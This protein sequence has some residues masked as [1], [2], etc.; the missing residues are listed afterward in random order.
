MQPKKIVFVSLFILLFF[1]AR[2]HF[3]RTP[4]F[5]E[6]GIFA[7]LVINQPENPNI[8]LGGR[9]DGEN[10]Y[11]PP[12]HPIE[13]YS[14]IKICGSVFRPY[15]A[16]VDWQNDAEITPR[17]RFVFSLFQFVILL[18]VSL[19][20]VFLR[21]WPGHILLAAILAAVVISPIALKTS[22]NLQ[23]DGSVG[24]L[25]NGLFGLALMLLLRK[26]SINIFTGGILF[27]ASIFLGIGKQEWTMV[28]LVAMGISTVYFFV[29]K[30]KTSQKIKPH[31]VMLLIILVGL[32]I[33]NITSYLCMPEA[34]LGGFRVMWD[35]SG[36]EKVFDGQTATEAARLVY[37]TIHRLPWICTSLAL[38]AISGL[39]VLSNRRWPK[40]V[41]FF[42]FIFGLGLFGAFFISLHSS[43]PRYFA[44]SLVVLTMAT[45]AV[46][47]QK[48]NSRFFVM[49]AMITLIMFVS[50]GAFFYTRTIKRPTKVYF[51]VKTIPLT[52][53]QAAII[54]P[55]VAWN[56]MELDFVN[57]Y[58][59]RW[60]AEWYSEKYNKKLYPT[61]LTWSDSDVRLED[62]VFE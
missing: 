38:I 41:E 61:D 57:F 37:L 24:V 2:F 52:S 46:F 13:L 60:G 20:I 56:K 45:V 9:A 6:E 43:D 8:L 54:S 28:L 27:A 47:P 32:I 4:L 62:R 34:Y 59:G 35:F 23:V 50:S 58:A 51:D 40:P 19:Y 29:L 22:W 33:G 14:V 55:G 21:K 53:G 36:A 5:G 12:S 11:S 3:Y 26:N 1:A 10:L 16:A 18:G 7:E 39:S 31:L 15:L 48:I 49:V 44:P 25:M 30:L 42:L 17:L